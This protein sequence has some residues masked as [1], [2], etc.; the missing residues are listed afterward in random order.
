[1]SLMTVPAGK[2]SKS[3]Y[4]KSSAPTP[5]TCV[6]SVEE[7]TRNFQFDFSISDSND[8]QPLAGEDKTGIISAEKT[9]NSKKDTIQKTDHPDVTAQ[10][11]YLMTESRNKG[12]SF[13]FSVD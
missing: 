11:Y 1:M 13:N 12:F 9:D 5:A 3:K 4:F 7:T 10:N 8:V 2:A 6:G